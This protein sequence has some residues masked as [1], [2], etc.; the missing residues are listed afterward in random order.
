MK[1]VRLNGKKGL[2]SDYWIVIQSVEEK[3]AR[4]A[5]N[6]F[7]DEQQVEDANWESLDV[8]PAKN[9][10]LLKPALNGFGR[11]LNYKSSH[12]YTDSQ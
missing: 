11:I 1:R 7:R 8:N 12:D 4:T 10:E 5:L 9:G 3:Q 2:V 6:R